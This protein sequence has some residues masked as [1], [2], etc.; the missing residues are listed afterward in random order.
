MAD[1]QLLILG[2]GFDLQCGLKSTFDDFEKKQLHTIKGLNLKLSNGQLLPTV[3]TTGPDGNKLVGRSFE[4]QFWH[5]GLTLWDLILRE[6]HIRRTWYDI[7]ECIRKWVVVNVT[8]DWHVRGPYSSRGSFQTH[9]DYESLPFWEKDVTDA[10]LEYANKMYNWDGKGKDLLRI[11]MNELHRFEA[12][13]A[14][15]LVKQTRN[16]PSYEKNALNLIQK[17]TYDQFNTDPY[18][19]EFHFFGDELWKHGTNILNFNY[20]SPLHQINTNPLVFNVHGKANKHNIIFGIDRTGVDTDLAMYS[21][22]VKFTKTYRLMALS[23]D[24]HPS[25]VQPYVAGTDLQGTKY[26]KFFGHSLERRTI[27]TSKRSS[28]KLTST[29]ARHT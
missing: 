13:F 2:N 3:N 12:A 9:F 23:S 1:T 21:E 4:Q 5:R 29:R 7:E 22:I 10:T 28:M 25:L 14:D 24:P 27:R 18:R 16:N 15:Y 19:Q 11:L 17:L 26:I 6:D 20:T 8:S